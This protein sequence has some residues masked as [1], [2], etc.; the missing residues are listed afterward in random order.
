M[1]SCQH[2]QGDDVIP[3]LTINL[4]WL[5]SASF[6]G[7]RNELAEAKNG[8]AKQFLAG[9]GLG[10]QPWILGA[11]DAVAAGQRE[12]QGLPH[13]GHR[14]FR[15]GPVQPLTMPRGVVRVAAYAPPGI[16]SPRNPPME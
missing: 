7:R 4:S 11:F 13:A 10:R 8:L 5:R 16:S 2:A 3:T 12:A 6:V 15:I 1:S 14:R 9:L